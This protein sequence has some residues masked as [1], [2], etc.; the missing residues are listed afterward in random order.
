MS[1]FKKIITTILSTTMVLSLAACGGSAGGDAVPSSGNASE[2]ATNTSTTAKK[3]DLNIAAEMIGDS[4]NHTQNWDSWF[5]V[6]YCIAET[7]VKFAEDGSYSPWLATSWESNDDATVWTFNLR[8]DVTFSNG[9]PMTASK[10]KDSIEFLYASTD[11]A[12]GGMGYPQNYFT[13]TNIEADD[14][15]LTLTITSETPVID[16][17]GCMGYPWTC[18]VDTEGIES[19]NLASEGPIGTGAYK[20]VSYTKDTSLTLEANE[21]YW[22]GEVP[23]E[24]VNAVYVPDSKIRALALMDGSADLAFNISQ[25]DRE[26]L[27]A[28]GCNVDLASG[29]RIGNSYLNMES[30][31]SDETVR[32]AIA[33]AIDGEAIA[34][35]T[36]SGSYMYDYSVLPTSYAFGGDE[37]VFPYEYDPEGA[38]ALLDDAG[39]VDTDGDGIRELDGENIVIDYVASNFRFLDIIPQAHTA[40]IEEIGIDINLIATDGHI[41]ELNNREFDIIV[42]SEVTLP[43]GDPQQFLGHWYTKGN[44]YSSYSNAEYDALYEKLQVTVDTEDRKNLIRDMQQILI[45]DAITI[46]YGFYGTNTCSTNTITGVVAS[47]SD[48]YWLTTDVKPVS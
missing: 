10:V 25:A 4:M 7:L 27:E 8:D 30:Q 36:T 20:L 35:V 26:T 9:T 19:R 17:P 24:T 5:T 2:P 40:L 12:N 31:L 37:L 33:M 32:K 29:S 44:N 14:D 1:L 18:I 15:N 23:F 28:G 11:V 41:D 21:N 39:I 48:Y 46:V 22:A 43:T 38:K 6:R 42:N 45:D 13:Y 34:E 16:M 47:T 3:T